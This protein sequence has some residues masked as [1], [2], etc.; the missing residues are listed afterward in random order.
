MARGP[1][2]SRQ[3][4]L[5]ADLA[6]AFDRI[7]H[8]LL[9]AQLGTF[10]ARKQVEGWLKAGVVEDGRFS[11]T[12]E[13]TPQGGVMNPGCQTWRFTGWNRPPGSATKAK[14]LM[15]ASRCRARRF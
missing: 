8:D 14:A 4:C 15:P 6:K 10:P 3:W 11:A 2:P 7:D 1:N 13:G 5:D 9:L 12:E